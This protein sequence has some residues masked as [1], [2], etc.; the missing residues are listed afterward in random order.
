MLIVQQ[1][2]MSNVTGSTLSAPAQAAIVQTVASV[3]GVSSEAVLFVGYTS[4][5]TSSSVHVQA[6]SMD[7]LA[8]T[9]TTVTAQ[10]FPAYDTLDDIFAFMSS[11]LTDALEQGSFQTILHDQAMALSAS[12]LVGTQ[13]ESATSI[14]AATLNNP[15]A[16]PTET[17]AVH[18]RRNTFPLPWIWI[19]VIVVTGSIAVLAGVVAW[20]CYRAQETNIADLE[21]APAPVTAVPE[22]LYELEQASRVIS[23]SASKESS[24]SQVPRNNA[25][26]ATNVQI[27]ANQRE[28]LAWI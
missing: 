24:A 20:R 17:P 13:P 3:L 10:D 21:A 28:E 12:E 6:E 22:N 18:S 9:Q 1:I 2:A 26:L 7:I 27:V 19:I 25:V 14:F 23:S 15:T 5:A 4:T 8:V 11:T 16:S